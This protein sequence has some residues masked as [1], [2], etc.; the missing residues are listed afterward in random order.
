MVAQAGNPQS[1][2][3][4]Y[5]CHLIHRPGREKRVPIPRDR[6]SFLSFSEASM[7]VVFAQQQKL[8]RGQQFLSQCNFFFT[9]ASS[10]YR[11]LALFTERTSGPV[12]HQ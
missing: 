12:S 1:T 9:V 8:S 11:Y 2:K 6:S 3:H 4:P 7:Y 5:P 10:D